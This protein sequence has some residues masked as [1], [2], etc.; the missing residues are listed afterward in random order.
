MYN[1]ARWLASCRDRV[2]G[3]FSSVSSISNTGLAEVDESSS[4]VLSV[5]SEKD[6]TYF[7]TLFKLCIG[8]KLNV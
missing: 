2:I 4:S 8:D 6:D 5:F 3:S 7:Y 1:D